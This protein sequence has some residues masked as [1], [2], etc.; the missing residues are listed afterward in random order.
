MK[1]SAPLVGKRIVL[2]NYRTSDLP[3]LTAMWFDA[4]NGKYLSDP[5]AAFVN[6]VYQRGLDDPENNKDGYY[7][8]AETTQGGVLVGSA[9]IFPT[10]EAST[11]LGTAYTKAIGGR[12]LVA[13]SLR[14]CW[15]G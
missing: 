10:A 2:R 3:F 9:G 11:T 13:R 5:T 7:L 4:E 14:V 12:A 15:S 8:V 6:D 1:I